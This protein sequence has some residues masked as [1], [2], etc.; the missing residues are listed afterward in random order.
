DAHDDHGAFKGSVDGLLA[1]LEA[2][3]MNPELTP[4]PTQHSISNVLIEV[5]GDVAYSEAYVESRS[6]RDGERHTALALYTA[7]PARRDGEWRIAD[8][9][10]ILE[11][12]G[13]GFTV[14]DFVRGYR[15][16]RDQ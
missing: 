14:S 15:D 4:G 5:D 3:T 16:R 10:V 8:R 6:I 11:H 13:P 9:R 7:R 2:K 12:A 1:Y